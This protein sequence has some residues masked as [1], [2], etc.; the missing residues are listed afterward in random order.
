MMAVLL[1]ISILFVFV[2]TRVLSS[3]DTI[4]SENTRQFLSM[5][6]ASIGEYELEFGDYP[7][8]SFPDELD[9]IPNRLNE[10]A[11]MLFLSLYSKEWQTRELPDER[12]GNSDQDSTKKSLSS[13]SRPSLF[14]VQDDW[15][16][17]I[18][19]I[20][21]RDYDKPQ[22]YVSSDPET[23]YVFEA[24]V[25]GRTNPDTGDPYNRTRFQLVSAGPDGEFGTEDDLANFQR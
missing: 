10:G 1:I 17:P 19:Y 25:K 5:L 11:E 6:E 2:I 15:D 9:S 20:H 16:N 24:V 7:P 3:E 4:L 23:G 8:S 13:F 14:E 18:V 12:L 22:T 21:R